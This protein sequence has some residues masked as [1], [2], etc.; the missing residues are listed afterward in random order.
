MKRIT[1]IILVTMLVVSLFAFVGCSNSN[2]MQ[3]KIEELQATVKQLSINVSKLTEEITKLQEKLNNLTN[4]TMERLKEEAI[5]EL[6]AYVNNKGEDKYTE[7]NW[8]EIENILTEF[9][10]KVSNVTTIEELNALL[11]VVKE[12]I[13]GVLTKM[14]ELLKHFDLTDPKEYWTG[15]E[16]SNFAT[17]VIEVTLRKTTTYPY[18]SLSDF[19]LD[20][21]VRLDYINYKPIDN[22]PNFRQK[23]SIQLKDVSN[24]QMES[25]VK[26]IDK[27]EFVKSVHVLYTDDVPVEI[28]GIMNYE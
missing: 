16:S 6:E 23:L 10:T 14:E 3:Q 25:I 9:K 5:W 19:D 20:C 15:F 7:E 17:D 21:A 12:E 26:Q 18:L 27:L 28:E 13:N 24:E 1:S 4:A 22:E 8:S 2:E 11:V